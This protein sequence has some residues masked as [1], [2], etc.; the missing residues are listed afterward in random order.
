M[1]KESASKYSAGKE[2]SDFIDELTVHN[3]N[4]EDP[5]VTQLGDK[6][7]IPWINE[8]NRLIFVLWINKPSGDYTTSLEA[9]LKM[10]VTWMEHQITIQRFTKSKYE[11]HDT[12]LSILKEKMQDQFIASAWK[13]METLWSFESW[14]VFL[15]NK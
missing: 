10:L 2:I 14:V 3:L 4:H 11:I 13:R 12:L 1:P 7:V 9:T 15:V 6:I 5:K 8:N